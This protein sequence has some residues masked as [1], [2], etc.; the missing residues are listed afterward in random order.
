MLAHDVRAAGPAFRQWLKASFEPVRRTVDDI[1]SD[2]LELFSTTRAATGAF[3]M[4][5]NRMSTSGQENIFNY[6]AFAQP[7]S[8]NLSYVAAKEL[9]IMLDDLAA[10]HHMAV[11]DVDALAAEYGGGTHL[12]DGIH[13]SDVLQKALRAE[14]LAALEHTT[15][16]VA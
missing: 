7:L 3:C 16:P 14:V 8:R 13:H 15:A 5:L 9:N 1:R 10:D 2:Y 12:T 6:S 4:V 11:I